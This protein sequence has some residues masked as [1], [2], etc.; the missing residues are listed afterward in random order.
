[1][2]GIELPAA[3]FDDLSSTGGSFRLEG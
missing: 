2:G 3:R 1:M